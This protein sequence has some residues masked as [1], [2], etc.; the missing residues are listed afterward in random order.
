MEGEMNASNKPDLKRSLT[1]ARGHYR[2]QQKPQHTLSDLGAFPP[3]TMKT[4]IVCTLG[5]ASSSEEV[6]RELILAGMDMVRLNFSHGTHEEMEAIFSTVRR[7]SS[8]FSEQVSIL[9]DI[10]GPKIRTGKVKEA[11]NVDVGDHIDVTADS[12]LGTPECVQIKYPHMM[13]D[14]D[15]G[16]KI[17]I[18]DG[19]VKLRVEAKKA[20]SLACVV[21]AGGQISDHKGCNIPKGKLSLN[22]ITEKDKKDLEL[23]AKLNPE[24]VAASFIG[25]GADVEKVRSCLRDFGNTDVKIMAKVERPGALDCIDE[26]ISASDAIMV[27]RGDLGVEIPTWGVPAAQKDI[28]RKC[29]REGKPVI[30]ATQMLESMTLAQRPTRAEASDVFNAVLDGADAVMLSGETSV[31]K[32]PVICVKTMDSIVGEAERFMESRNPD[33]YDSANPGN[34]E[35]MGHGCFTMAKQFNAQGISGKIVTIATTG[36]STRMVSKYRPNIPILAFTANLRAA[37]ELNVVWGVQSI[38]SPLVTGDSVEEK[39][40]NAIK[41]GLDLDLIDKNDHVIVVASS[42]LA[43]SSGVFSGIYSVNDLLAEAPDTTH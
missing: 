10:Q 6:L 8:E 22:I 39:A 11:F 32:F 30:V 33:H 3:T 40:R 24:Y 19:I 7:I 36:Y 26:I 43:P 14:L 16:D 1:A 25:N 34:A 35:L 41:M 31:G 21:E 2:N 13:E 12:V 28:V 23:I 27:A 5:P 18:N 42:H 15:V 20:R 4:K 17:F 38:Y 29:N 37:R 9:C